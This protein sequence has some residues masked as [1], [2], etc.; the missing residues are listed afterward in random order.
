M[1]VLHSQLKSFAALSSSLFY[2]ESTPQE[3]L[4][5]TSIPQWPHEIYKTHTNLYKE[6][7]LQRNYQQA[8][9]EVGALKKPFGLFDS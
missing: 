4:K 9:V 7:T 2:E 6:C 8:H 3:S 1:G 5:P